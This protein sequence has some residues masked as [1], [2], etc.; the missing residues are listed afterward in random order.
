VL[1]DKVGEYLYTHII[2][3]NHH[4][5]KLYHSLATVFYDFYFIFVFA[6]FMLQAAVSV[7]L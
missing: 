5:I 6:S 1:A 2:A 4:V 7:S 3:L